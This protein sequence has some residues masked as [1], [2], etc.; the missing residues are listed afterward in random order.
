MATIGELVLR[1]QN[2]YSR[3]AASDDS[4]LSNRLIYSKMKSARAFILDQH[5][6]QMNVKNLYE[7]LDCVSLI[8]VSKYECECLD[9]Y[10]CEQLWRSEYELPKLFQFSYG[11][12]LNVFNI[13]I[14]TKK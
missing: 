14:G 1:V 11:H 12:E 13:K 4:R 2:L 3:G 8:E 9:L 5:K 6:R 7:Y 10:A